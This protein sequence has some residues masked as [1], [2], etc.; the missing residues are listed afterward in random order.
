[1]V[2]LSEKQFEKIVARALDDIPAW[3]SH[4]M[5]NVAIVIQP[6]PTS[7]QI[8]KNQKEGKMLLGLYEGIPLTRRSRAYR[9]V[10][11]DRITLFQQPL[12]RVAQDEQDLVRLVRRTVTHEIGH[13]FGLSEQALKKLGI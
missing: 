2:D 5:E 3:I 10:P 7:Q 1:M 6:W 11:P 8:R 4:R 9:L 12:Q 13:H